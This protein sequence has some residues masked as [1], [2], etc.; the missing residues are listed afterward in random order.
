MT[1]LSAL[2]TVALRHIYLIVVVLDAAGL[3]DA[4]TPVLIGKSQYCRI[5]GINLGSGKAEIPPVHKSVAPS[6]V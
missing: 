5:R 6:A 1:T 4:T 3:T 2:R